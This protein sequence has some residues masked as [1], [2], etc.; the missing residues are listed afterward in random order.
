MK[1]VFVTG[2][3]TSVGKSHVC[4]LLLDYSLRHRI[5]A[6][7]QKWV[8]TGGDGIPEDLAACLDAA[9]RAPDPAMI[10][11]QTPFRFARPASPHLAAE[12]Q[13]AI[14][15]PARIIAAFQ[16]LRQKAE[17]LI[18][19]GVGG[20]LV[21]LRRDFLLIDLVL[22]LSLPVLIVS[23]SGL[24]T[25]N[26][27]LLTIEALRHRQIRILGVVFSD[28][29]PGLEESLVVDNMQTIAAMG[30]VRVFG[31][32]RRLAADADSEKAGRA[33]AAVGAGI[34]HALG[35]G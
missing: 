13:K 9:G 28:E 27:T 6:M 3:D 4:G 18:V 22:Q 19:E 25:L 31:R 26:H 10:D 16:H 30:Q 15:E 20:I 32:L 35:V 7:Y 34:L 17:L 1:S 11:L 8:S 29:R 23:R 14:I 24:G 5:G 12:T 21:P 33:F 2:T